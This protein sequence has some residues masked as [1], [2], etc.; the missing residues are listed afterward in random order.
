[1]DDNSVRDVLISDEGM[2]ILMAIGY[3]GVPHRETKS[4]VGTIIQ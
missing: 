3:R 4:S 1:M 2:E